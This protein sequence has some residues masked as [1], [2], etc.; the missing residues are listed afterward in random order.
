MGDARVCYSYVAWGRV[1]NLERKSSQ[2]GT[3]SDKRTP[4][5]GDCNRWVDF[6]AIESKWTDDI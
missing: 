6:N 1:F 4:R 2:L 3:V 5:C